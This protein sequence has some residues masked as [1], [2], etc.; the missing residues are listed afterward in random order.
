ML[1]TIIRH[2]VGSRNDRLIKK[3]RAVVA[4]INGLQEQVHAMSD[5]ELQGQTARLR[6]RVGNG[7]PLD[8][9]LPEA[10]ATV[11][12]AARRVMGLFHYDVQLIGGY[13]LHE[14]KI[15]EMRTGEGKTLVATLPAYLNALTGKGV[16]VV[17]V[18]DYLASR[19]AEWMGRVHRFLGLSV[20]TI[21]ANLSPEERRAAYAADI[22]YG[23]NNEF[24][25]DYLR[26]NMAFS[27]AER[28]QRGL[29]YAI[30]DEVDSILID[31]A[32]T[33]LI[34]SG[35]TEENTDLYQK[36]D[37]LIPQFVAD[38][39]F[40]IDE[41]AKQVLLTEEG[42]EKAEQLMLD[43]GLLREGN[44]YDV[45]NVSL[46]HH[47]NQ[48]LRAHHIYH[49]ETDYIVRDGEVCIVDEFTGRMMTGRRWSDGLHQ[50]VEAKEG[51]EI[52]NESQTLAS[53]TFQNYFRMYEKLSGMT[54]TADTEAFE[55]NQIY[56]LEVVVIPTHR[57]IQ[58]KDLADQIYRTAAEKWDAITADIEA[59]RERGQPVLVGTT[60]IEHNEYLSRCLQQKKIPHSV[61]NAKQHEREAEIIAQAGKSGAVT[62]ATNMAG[63]GTDIVLGGNVEHQI[64][65]IEAREDLDDAAK[66]A[67]AQDLR[68]GWGAEHDKTLAAGGLHI[69]GT[70]RHESRRVD[71]Q[72]R[73]RAG[74]QGDVGSSRFYL[75]LEDPLM[76]IFG[77]DRLGGLMQKLGMQPGEAIE[78]P[79]VTKSIE[80]A[81][82]KVE[83]RNFDIR[84]QLLEYDDVANE[85]RKIIYAQRNAFMDS[86]NLH[87]EVESLRVDVLD[88]LLDDYAPAGVMEEQWDIE[89]LELALERIFAEKFPVGEWLA[90]DRTLNHE[91]LQER[92]LEAVHARWQER[93]AL[94]GEEMARHLEKSVTLQVLDSQWKDHL[95]SMDHLREGIHLRGYA[96]K[97]PKQEY[98]RESLTLFNAMLA[99]VREE[100]VSTLSHVQV[101]PVSETPAE[102]MDWSSLFPSPPTNQG[103]V[104]QHP[105]LPG[106]SSADEDRD[107]SAVAALGGAAAMPIHVQK[108]GRNQPCPCGSGKKYKHCCGRLG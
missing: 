52:Q 21:I 80:N 2:V 20:G 30:I 19:D 83:A 98:K 102:A 18:N 90:A 48:G 56:G 88:A 87:R 34:I 3:A 44:L 108:V 61:L 6:E 85:Q 51:V 53:I 55:L 27:P 105:D 23:T 17:T 74:R 94:M 46:V 13:M 4:R 45:Q 63:R 40:T 8:S 49:R 70:E 26:D 31:E 50:A 25:F 29:H 82:R 62:I 5:A 86:D 11:R 14:G 66:A 42:V 41:K 16:H 38:E 68:D 58:R 78:H 96:Q 92:I 73:G 10:F 75:S 54:G 91:G 95:A 9:I 32:R 103:L 79:W 107:L 71:N 33:P 22:T 12:E 69:I 1:G 77:S 47:L 37:K 93:E 100:I 36:V 39:D 60:S 67:Q 106:G 59:C 84:K 64:E 24:G 99:R 89:G 97:N 101:S 72:L 104:F 76:R 7:E 57:P 65:M 35:P 81:Q 15:A 28:V 43:N